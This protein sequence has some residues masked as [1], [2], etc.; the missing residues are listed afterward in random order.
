MSE[1][2]G[3][4]A[5]DSNGNLVALDPSTG[6]IIP[7]PFDKIDSQ[8]VDHNQ[9]RNRT[10]DGDT[11]KPNGAVV[12]NELG[13]PQVADPAN[14][15]QTQGRSIY[16]DGSGNVAAGIYIHDGTSYRRVSQWD[17]ENGSV[18]PAGGETIGDGTTTANHQSV[19]TEQASIGSSRTTHTFPPEPTA[20]QELDNS[21]PPGSYTTLALTAPDADAQY[22]IL[23]VELQGDGS[24]DNMRFLAREAGASVDH[25]ALRGWAG[26]GAFSTATSCI[27]PINNNQEIEYLT[28]RVARVI[29]DTKGYF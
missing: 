22:A 20:T 6:E 25:V 15:P 7:V 1:I 5:F 24:A 13:L 21:S 27:C 8:A 11:L 16:V 28:N 9:T 2:V 12:A 4:L 3:R 18:I 10:H 19:S 14:A 29:I 17:Q 23:N 26:H